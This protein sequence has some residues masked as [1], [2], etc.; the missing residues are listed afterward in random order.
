MAHALF[1]QGRSGLLSTQSG[2][3]CPDNLLSPV[4]CY[5]QREGVEG[6]KNLHRGPRADEGTVP[7]L[8]P[9]WLCLVGLHLSRHPDLPFEGE[10]LINFCRLTDKSYRLFQPQA[11]GKGKQAA[12]FPFPSSGTDSHSFPLHTLVLLMP[13]VQVEGHGKAE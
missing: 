2:R 1:P 12:Q 6:L 4:C 5:S 11:D 10:L 8:A 9:H 3:S 7:A 13:R